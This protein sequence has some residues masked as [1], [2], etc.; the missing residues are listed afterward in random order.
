MWLLPKLFMFYPSYSVNQ[1]IFDN[2]DHIT[3][4]QNF[5]NVKWIKR[6]MTVAAILFRGLPCHSLIVFSCS[7]HFRFEKIPGQGFLVFVINTPLPLCLTKTQISLL[8]RKEALAQLAVFLLL[9][10]KDDRQLVEWV[11]PYL[12]NTCGCVACQ[13]VIVKS[14]KAVDLFHD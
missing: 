12:S 9:D 8:H 3:T 1:I 2:L 4:V 10:V 13:V 14:L 6:I 11:L 7:K 5:N